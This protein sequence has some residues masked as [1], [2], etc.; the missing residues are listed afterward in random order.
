MVLYHYP[1]KGNH[2]QHTLR[3]AN[4]SQ[5]GKNAPLI[6]AHRMCTMVFVNHIVG[7]QSSFVIFFL[8]L[9]NFYRKLKL[10]NVGLFTGVFN[11]ADVD[12]VPPPTLPLAHCRDGIFPD[13][14][15]RR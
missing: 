11:Q 2:W 13:V 7:R 10:L 12:N 1:S 14:L 3:Q 15:L 8:L 6:I 4:A 9:C 5:P